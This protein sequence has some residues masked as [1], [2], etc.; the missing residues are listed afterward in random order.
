M[1]SKEEFRIPQAAMSTTTV[2]QLRVRYEGCEDEYPNFRVRRIPI[3]VTHSFNI[4][5]I[6]VE[7]LLCARF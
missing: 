2:S 1:S 3:R 5:K 4:F 6:L 7:H